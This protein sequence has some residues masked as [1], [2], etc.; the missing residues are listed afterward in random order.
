M[1]KEKIITFKSTPDN[2]RKEYLGLK[3][4]TMR[5]FEGIDNREELLLRY[6]NGLCNILFIEIS[7]TKTQEIFRRTVTDVTKFQ[8]YYIISW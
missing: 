5:E 3:R 1:S 2:W 4:N 8:Y 7:N 6:I